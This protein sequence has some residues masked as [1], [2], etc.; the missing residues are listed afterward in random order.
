MRI[1]K[2]TPYTETPN[3]VLVG[4]ADAGYLS[5]P[6]KARSQTGSIITH[7]R[8]TS[9]LNSTTEEPTCIYEDNA[10]C[11]EQMKQGYIKGDNTKHIYPQFFYNQQQQCL[12]N[13]QVNKVPSDENVAE[14]FTKSLPKSLFEKNVKSI[15]LR[16]LSELP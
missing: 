15:G 11:I 9:G 5:D 7:I 12:L 16:K 10:A 2:S 1:A 13:I 3:N 4:F 6:H 14:L 8:G